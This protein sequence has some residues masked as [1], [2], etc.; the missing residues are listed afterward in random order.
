MIKLV[1]RSLSARVIFLFT[2]VHVLM[3]ALALVSQYN[4]SD[5]PE[6][7][8]ETSSAIVLLR[9]DFFFNE[10]YEANILSEAKQD[11]SLNSIALQSVP[12]S[13]LQSD[14]FI[15]LSTRNPKFWFVYENESYD[16]TFSYGQI[17]TDNDS[18][19][20]KELRG[21][22]IAQGCAE[23]SI[24][25]EYQG[26]S[27]S[28]RAE[29]CDTT[30]F[31]L[32]KV[33]GVE[34]KYLGL[35]RPFSELL[36]NLLDQ[37]GPLILS[38]FLLMLITPVFIYFLIR[39]ISRASRAARKISPYSD[40][41]TLPTKGGFT[42]AQGLVDSVNAAFSRLGEGYERE[43]WLRDVIAHELRTPL[44]IFR[45]RL[46]DVT[47]PVLKKE[48]TADLHKVNQLIDR[49]LEFSKATRLS[50][51]GEVLSLINETRAACAE[52]G[53][54]AIQSNV[55]IDFSYPEE[56]QLFIKANSTV[57]FIVLTNLI[58][59]AIKHSE[60]DEPIKVKIAND[61]EI[62]ISDRGVG[63]DVDLYKEFFES[64]S[65][66]RVS[67][68]RKHGLGLIIVAELIFFSNGEIKIYQAES[69]GVAFSLRFPIA[70][71][72]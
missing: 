1:L 55:D 72:A 2:S 19:A 49:L 13:L 27:V 60:S 51:K 18:L 6:Y 14:F 17:P 21:L 63:M 62:V 64:F 20:V 22:E 34:G 41:K 12:A 33:G 30:G 59:N 25:S 32:I 8:G 28:T 50:N 11:S 67:N 36:F 45:A 58:N 35:S 57:V 48:L 39:P 68:V 38:Y 26:F 7:Y 69:G 5:E 37:A 61:G 71:Q 52:C 4:V 9:L 47:D 16:F 65:L 54:L 70:S 23:V 42:E 53:T 10:L 31:A 66:S 56:K 44:T 29:K 40:V 3:L 24:P 46:E 15:D 43:R